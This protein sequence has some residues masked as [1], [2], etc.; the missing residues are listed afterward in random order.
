MPSAIRPLLGLVLMLSLLGS[1]AAHAV[2]RVDLAR[3]L[4]LP[5]PAAQNFT[6]AMLD[7]RRLWA[8]L[9]E[10]SQGTR[11]PCGRGRTAGPGAGGR[12]G[13]GRAADGPAAGGREA[14]GVV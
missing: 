8:D 2:G 1:E 6:P 12:A 4:E 10:E 5:A 11:P 7:L 14:T 3:T 13:A 9:A